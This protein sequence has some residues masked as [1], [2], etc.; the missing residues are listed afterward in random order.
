MAEV[1]RTYYDAETGFV[2]RRIFADPAVYEL[3]LER[4][5]ARAWNFMCHESQIPKPGDFFMNAIGEDEVI[6]VRGR[7]G[8]VNVLLNTCAHRGNSVCRAEIGNARSFYCP[9]HGWNYDLDGRLIGVRGEDAFYRGGLDR[10]ASGLARA[11]QVESY[12]GF[13]FATLD[14]AAPPLA[15][16]LGWVGRLG[17]DLV[18]SRGEVEFLDGVRKNRIKCNWK[19]AVDNLYDWY[20]VAVTHRSALAVGV[21]REEALRPMNQLV[22]LGDFGHGIGGPGLT[23]AEFDRAV[24]RLR[25]GERDAGE[26]QF[27]DGRVAERMAPDVQRLLGPVGKRVLG[28]P[29]I[30]P[31]LWISSTPEV[32]LRLPRGPEETELWWFAYRTKDMDERK[33]RAALHAT[34]RLF[35]AAGLLEQD[36]GENW[37]LATRSARGVHARRLPHN[38]TMGKGADKVRQH[39]GQPHVATV[40]NEHG[41]RWTYQSWQ[42]WM[43]ADSWETLLANRSTPPDSV[44]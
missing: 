36:D 38:L 8:R 43:R 35:A 24:E 15:D 22:L 37:R 34:N 40:F 11:A 7:D 3:E 14:A 13:V 25:N 42:D 18:A 10:E 33:R 26:R 44:A 28:H 30:F 5:F 19:L 39:A 12:R 32:C 2:D 9:Y 31:N 16:Y 27:Y 20:H 21:L 23:E 6:V 4:I 41:Q 1:D 17:I 29:N